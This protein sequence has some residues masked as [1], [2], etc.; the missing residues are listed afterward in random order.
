MLFVAALKSCG[1]LAPPKLSHQSDRNS[2]HKNTSRWIDDGEIAE[3]DVEIV[4]LL[5]AL[6]FWSNPIAICH[7]E[8]SRMCIRIRLVRG[9]YGFWKLRRRGP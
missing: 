5:D 4:D 7:R 2:K 6:L 1:L 9:R 8:R 3:K